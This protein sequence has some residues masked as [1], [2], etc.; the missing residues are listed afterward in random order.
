MVE[1]PKTQERL[2]SAEND[3]SALLQ[4]VNDLV[5]KVARYRDVE[6]TQSLLNPLM[7]ELNRFGRDLPNVRALR[8]DYADEWL[9]NTMAGRTPRTTPSAR[10]NQPRRTPAAPEDNWQRRDG[11]R[12][13][14][15]AGPDGVD[16]PS[17]AVGPSSDT[18]DAPHDKAM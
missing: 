7:E 3:R 15:L 8:G 1:N 6:E 17:E 10:A 11:A 12:K 9:V 13:R 18:E 16:D 14:R 4:L 2:S 5:G